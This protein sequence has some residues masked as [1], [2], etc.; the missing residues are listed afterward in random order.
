[1][2]LVS[3]EALPLSLRNKY[4]PQTSNISQTLVA[5]EIVDHSDHVVGAAP[6]GLMV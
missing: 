2:A 5:N 4:Y 1:M 6:T 3:Q